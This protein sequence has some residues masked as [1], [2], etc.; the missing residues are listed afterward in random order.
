M[1]DT[2]TALRLN[3]DGTL[4][5]IDI[6]TTRHEQIR[7]IGRAL[8]GSAEAVDY[9]DRPGTTTAVVAFSPLI[10]DHQPVNSLAAHAVHTIAQALPRPFHGPV[11][12]IG[13]TDD[14]H[15]VGL[16]DDIAAQLRSLATCPPAS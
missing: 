12:F 8:L 2:A 10:R 11:L 6:G 14:G 7:R 5:T 13:Y 9:F 16:P 3:L 1:T 15:M 4:T